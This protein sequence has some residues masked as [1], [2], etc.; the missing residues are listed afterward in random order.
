MHSLNLHGESLRGRIRGFLYY[1]PDLLE[2]RAILRTSR[3]YG[4]WVLLGLA[5]PTILGGLISGSWWGARTGFLWGGPVRMFVV[6]SRFG[7]QLGTAQHRVAAVQFSRQQSKQ[8]APRFGDL[9]RR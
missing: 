4:A 2:D 5:I 1:T 9:G 8:L 6:A 3:R 7:A